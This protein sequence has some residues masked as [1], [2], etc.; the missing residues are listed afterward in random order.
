MTPSILLCPDTQDKTSVCDPGAPSA[1][2]VSLPSAVEL[3]LVDTF[4]A[5]PPST[6]Q[7]N[8]PPYGTRIHMMSA[9]SPTRLNV[10]DWPVLA[11]CRNFA[12]GPAVPL[13]SDC[14]IVVGQANVSSPVPATPM[15]PRPPPVTPCVGKRERNWSR[16]RASQRFSNPDDGGPDAPWPSVMESPMQTMLHRAVSRPARPANN[17]VR[18]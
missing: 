9:E 8:V 14:E 12:F 16:S 4:V 17:G 18:A 7:E 2:C 6:A 15:K 3:P 5:G 11:S 1:R 10:I 13:V